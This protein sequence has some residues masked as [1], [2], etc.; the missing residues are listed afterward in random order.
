M[1]SAHVNIN[2]RAS[3]QLEY[4]L[5]DAGVDERS[6]ATYN[7]HGREGSDIFNTVDHRIACPAKL[8]RHVFKCSLTTANN[9]EKRLLYIQYITKDNAWAF[10]QIVDTL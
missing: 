9:I 4:L 6:R 2:I 7:R 3:T 1:S 5:A 10:R 8:A